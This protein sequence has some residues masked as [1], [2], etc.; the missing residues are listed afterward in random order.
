MMRDDEK[1]V[2]CLWLA[3]GILVIGLALPLAYRGMTTV[4]T[5]GTSIGVFL[6]GVGFSLLIRRWLTRR[7]R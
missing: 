6:L 3:A 4:C 1:T 7:R 2:I 5:I